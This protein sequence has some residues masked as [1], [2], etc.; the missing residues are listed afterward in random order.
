VRGNTNISRQIG[1]FNGLRT[2]WWAR[3]AYV[4][5]RQSLTSRSLG[6][7]GGARRSYPGKA[8]IRHS[9]A[10]PCLIRGVPGMIRQM[11]HQPPMQP[12]RG[13]T[14]ALDLLGDVR[15]GAIASHISRKLAQFRRRLS[16]PFPG[17]LVFVQR[18][19]ML[20]TKAPIL[21]VRLVHYFAQM[22]LFM[23]SVLCG[24]RC[25]LCS[26][27]AAKHRPDIAMRTTQRKTNTTIDDQWIDVRDADQGRVHQSQSR[28]GPLTPRSSRIAMTSGT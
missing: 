16:A 25:G 13:D 11:F 2:G 10:G 1:H 5:H 26:A 20:D 9:S 6:A 27:R 19:G 18:K 22:H 23:S 3:D 24:R 28:N 8:R 14:H 15:R 4:S 17:H 7:V 12:S 21:W